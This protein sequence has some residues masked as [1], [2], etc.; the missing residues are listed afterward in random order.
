MN[1]RWIDVARLRLRSLFLRERVESELDR[2]MRAHL[3]A[4]IEEHMARGM[5]P[6]EARRLAMLE[7]GGMEQMKEESRDTRGVAFAE[8][9]GRDLRH[10]LRSLLR[11]PL[12][13]LAAT[14]S[15]ALGAAANVAVFGL[16][17]EL[18]FATPDVRDAKRVVAMRTSHSSHATY[19]RW[20]DLD[21]SGA[22]DRVA[23]YDFGLGVNWFRGDA[24]VSLATMQ[25]TSNYFEVIGAPLAL[26]RGFSSEEARAES[27]PRV[28]VVS[29]AFWRRDLG[30][31]SSAVGRSLTLNGV[32]YTITGVLARNMRTLAGFGIA[33]SVWLPYSPTLNPDITTRPV[34]AIQLVGRLKPGQS[35]AEGRAAIDAADK[36]LALAVHDSLGGV[37]QFGLVGTVGDQKRATLA[38]FFAMAGVVSLLVLLIACANVAGLLVARATTR[39]SEIAIRL[40]IGGSRS[41]LI[42]QLMTEAFWLAAIGTAAGL[43]LAAIAMRAVASMS[44]P[45]DLPIELNLGIDGGILLVALAVLLATT[46]ASAL[47]PSLAATRLSLAPALKREDTSRMGPRFTTRRLLLAG[48]VVVSTVLLVTAFLFVRNL[49]RSRDTSPGFDVDPVLVAHVGLVRARPGEAQNELLERLSERARTVPGVTT[50]AFSTSVPLTVSGGSTSGRSVSFDD[51]PGRHHVEYSRMEVGIGYFGVLGV[52]LLAGRDFSRDDRGGA[53]RVMIV[54]E[55]FARRY[56]DGEAVGR[57]VSYE[58]EK[59]GTTYQIVGVVAN[60]KYRTLGEEQR[61]AIYLP[62]SQTPPNRDVAFVLARV[63]GD[64]AGAVSVLRSALIEV[65]RSV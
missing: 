49:Q 14:T 47:L 17:R 18:V 4:M 35:V 46:I 33:P 64:V 22:I 12:L 13:L 26:G 15:I 7:F 54:N 1:G 21:A 65:D 5:S 27:D 50:S 6:V 42:Q 37:I 57:R 43:S 25:V 44:L 16:A 56:L 63:N 38:I 41:R 24:T 23:G 29:H 48:Q 10:G 8:N 61:A 39:R 19:Q 45:I 60:G 58:G 40:A 31:D 52:R 20:R 28:A 9:L 30:G 55:A 59:E 11:E 32:S 3:H 62:L 53:P 34:Q 36:R 51:R 2:E